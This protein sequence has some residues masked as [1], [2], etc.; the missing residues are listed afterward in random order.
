MSET[1]SRLPSDSSYYPTVSELLSTDP[2]DL[3]T[4]VAKA[5]KTTL[6]CLLRETLSQLTQSLKQNSTLL[7]RITENSNVLNHLNQSIVNLRKADTLSETETV[8]IQPKL[9]DAVTKSLEQ[10][11]YDKEADVTLVFYNVPEHDSNTSPTDID[12]VLAT[13][14]VPSD[15]IKQR[16]RLGP[17]NTDKNARPRP[18]E[19]VLTTVFDRRAAL[20]NAPLLKGSGV[21]VKRKLCWKERLKE[22]ELLRLRYDLSQEGFDRKLFRIRDL[23]LFYNGKRLNESDDITLIV[24]QLKPTIPNEDPSV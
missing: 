9:I 3:G 12:K 20:S 10:R 6:E 17:A 18:L 13:L 21:F 24:N 22:K 11:D 16:K 5:K 14:K 19:I 4:F 7:E 8:P 23:K 1:R 2:V 15:K